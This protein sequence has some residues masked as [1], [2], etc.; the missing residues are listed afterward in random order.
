MSSYSTQATLC[1]WRNYQ[2]LH[3]QY[4][5]NFL[6]GDSRCDITQEDAGRFM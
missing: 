4:R 3:E 5:L 6:Y 2:Q 1:A